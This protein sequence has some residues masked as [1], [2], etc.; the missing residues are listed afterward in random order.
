M[1]DNQV[2]YLM[3]SIM[4]NQK[5]KILTIDLAGYALFLSNCHQ[6]N[7]FASLK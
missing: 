3:F 2:S 4:Q 7:I 1:S 5:L 6:K